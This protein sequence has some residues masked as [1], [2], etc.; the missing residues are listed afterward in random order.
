MKQKYSFWIG[1][2]KTIKNCLV[3]FAPAILAFLANV[4]AEYGV[5]AGFVTYL[6]KNWLE[7][8]K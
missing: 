4:P 3:V 2:K 7:N 1:L 6:F 5:I 8:R